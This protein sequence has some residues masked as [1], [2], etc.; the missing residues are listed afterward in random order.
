MSLNS[1]GMCQSLPHSEMPPNKALAEPEALRQSLLASAS[2][3]CC[4]RTFPPTPASPQPGPK[5]LPQTAVRSG[6]GHGVGVLGAP[7]GPQL[8][9]QRVK[10]LQSYNL[11]FTSLETSIYMCGS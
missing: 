11:T 6:A 2:Q 9:G 8:F 10:K 7:C 5:D 3:L 4:S 1:S